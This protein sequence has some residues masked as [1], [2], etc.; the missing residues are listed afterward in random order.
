M[1]PIQVMEKDAPP[2]ASL[3]SLDAVS[4]DLIH[5]GVPDHLCVSSS[6]LMWHLC[7]ALKALKAQQKGR[8][9][10]WRKGKKE[11]RGR[12]TLKM[13]SKSSLLLGWFGWLF[14]KVILVS[15]T[16]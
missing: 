8:G 14:P 6:L 1:N 11:R 13:T 10:E 7:C 16:D 15:D 2:Y 9:R 12:K 3:L 5:A 4:G